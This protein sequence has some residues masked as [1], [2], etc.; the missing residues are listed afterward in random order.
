VQYDTSTLQVQGV[1]DSGVSRVL[2]DRRV[3]EGQANV[4][5]YVRCHMRFACVV[6]AACIGEAGHGKRDCVDALSLDLGFSGVS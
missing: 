6:H 4:H 5:M 3:C 1:G 2:L